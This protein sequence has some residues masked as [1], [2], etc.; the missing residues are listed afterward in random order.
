MQSNSNVAYLAPQLTALE[1]T[2]IYEEIAA[3]E[4]CGINVV[5]F[6]VNR[7][8][9]YLEGNDSLLRRTRYL[10]DTNKLLIILLGLFA[11]LFS[12]KRG[13]KALRY[14][15]HDIKKVGIFSKNAAKLTFQFFAGA[16]LSKQLK[17]SSC[18][19]LHI[20]FA[21]VAT[22]IGMYAATMAAIPFTVMAHANDIFERGLLLKEKAD[23]SKKLFTISDYN[24][25][26]LKSKEVNCS[27]IAIIRCGVDELE[28]NFKEFD[29]SEVVRLGTLGRLVEKKGVEDLLL[30]VKTLISKGV[31]VSLSVG[32]DG[33]MLDELKTKAKSLQIE[34]DVHF[35]GAIPRCVLN[36]WM[37]KVDVFVLA[38]KKDRNGDQDGIPVVLME[39]MMRS[40]PVISTSLSGIPEL[41]IDNKTGLLAEPNSPLDLAS[42]IETLIVDANIGSIVEN[43]HNF[44]TKEFG[45]R[46]NTQRLISFFKL[47]S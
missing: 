6:S 29:A 21:H 10:Y 34:N 23:R 18:N 8:L 36:E 37:Q 12:G 7:P 17:S 4:K 40:V 28:F 22:Q 11:L 26:Y 2:F 41:I 20:H 5:P 42:K 14:L 46:V 39:A 15:R 45:R 19:H 1:A 24:K 31:R 35:E 44:T 16:M 38:C 47:C 32:G 13:L 33:P 27:S 43:A 3:V 25:Q 9:A 30:A